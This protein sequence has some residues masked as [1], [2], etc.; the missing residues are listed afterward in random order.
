MNIR[1]YIESGI[2]ELYVMNALPA[3][4]MAEVEAMA[5]SNPEIQREIEDI[6]AVMQVYSQAHAITPRP[7]LKE[8]ILNK[9]QAETSPT[10][11]NLQPSTPSTPLS[12]S[13]I[14]GWVAAGILGISTLYFYQQYQS[15]KTVKEKCEQEQ[16]LQMLKNQKQVA[17]LGQKLNIL[18]SPE[19]K[20][21]FLNSPTLS[22]D[23]RATVYWNTKEK[24]T[25]LTIQNLPR[26]TSDKQYQLWALV[27]GVPIDA[28]VF[29]Y[30]TTDI[31]TMKTIENADTFAV[32]IE[33]QGGSAKPTIETMC[34]LG[35]L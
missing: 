9:I 3:N 5:H 18:K 10:N 14:L 8:Q 19:T 35:T 15:F 20:T 11:P 28:G 4:E 26:T 13:T 16:N 32:T 2:I 21:V 29:D 27:K 30:N 7:E 31:Q 6:Q 24:T 33:P 17:D 23:L 34:A 1:E 25:L 12:I 22:K